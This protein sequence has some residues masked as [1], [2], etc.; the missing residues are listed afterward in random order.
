MSANYGPFKPVNVAKTHQK[1]KLDF[2]SKVHQDFRS[3]EKNSRETKDSNVD[4]TRVINR[5]IAYAVASAGGYTEKRFSLDKGGCTDDWIFDG[6]LGV[7]T[8]GKKY[9][10][11]I[12]NTIVAA[13]SGIQTLFQFTKRFLDHPPQRL[14]GYMDIPANST[15][16]RVSYGKFRLHKNL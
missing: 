14:P 10:I 4:L 8:V 15:E 9:N 3:I 7:E 6:P 11:F 2:F 13:I 12:H 5:P 1:G 16:G